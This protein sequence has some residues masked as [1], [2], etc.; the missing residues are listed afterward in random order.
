MNL[1]VLDYTEI[2]VRQVSGTEC[3]QQSHNFAVIVFFVC[4]CNLG[5]GAEREEWHIGFYHTAYSEHL[6]ES[7]TWAVLSGAWETLF[8]KR[9]LEGK[10]VN[11]AN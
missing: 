7:E 10:S 4:C 6:N 2:K 5:E 11:S 8:L 9:L 3:L 1:P